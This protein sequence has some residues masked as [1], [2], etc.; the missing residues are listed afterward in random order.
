MSAAGG[1]ITPPAS[2][3]AAGRAAL[4]RLSEAQS[5]GLT[6]SFG[7]AVQ[8]VLLSLLGR[9]IVVQA[10]EEIPLIVCVLAAVTRKKKTE[11]VL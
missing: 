10:V 1:E 7:L 9:D 5:K 4:E 6:L 8:H 3:K 11:E 2:P